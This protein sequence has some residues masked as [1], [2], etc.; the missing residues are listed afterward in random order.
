MLPSRARVQQL[1]YQLHT[2]KMGTS[3]MSEY[4]QSV[5][6]SWTIW[7]QWLIKLP[8]LTSS[9]PYSVVCLPNMT[10]LS[11]PSTQK[12]T[13]YCQKNSSASCLARRFIMGMLSLHQTP[14]PSTLLL[15]QFILLLALQA[16]I[17]LH[18]F[19]VVLDV[20]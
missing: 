12:S 11:P 8:T 16:T 3:S 5:K 9:L 13:L 6:P 14:Q 20:A 1:K 19:F 2:I 18:L 17:Q 7:R 15:L 10:R 4:I